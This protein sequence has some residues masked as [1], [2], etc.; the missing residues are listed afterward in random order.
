MLPPNLLY[1][2][3]DRQLL[4]ANSAPPF[5]SLLNLCHQ[6]ALAGVDFIQVREKDLTAR[7]LCYLTE[8]VLHQVRDTTTKVLINDRVDVALATGA[9]GVHLR[10][11]SLPIAAVREGIGRRLLIAASVHSLA[12]AQQVGPWADFLLAGPVFDTPS[13]RA[14]GAALGLPI[15]KDIIAAVTCPVVA[16]GGID[17]TNW[18]W[19]LNHGAAGVAA[20][21]LWAEIPDLAAF[22][23]QVKQF[24]RQNAPFPFG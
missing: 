2:I 10:E 9:H 13:K 20:I 18:Q 23:L 4:P 22:V 8:A 24:T 14:Y 7:D 5:K 6:A 11:S 12:V 15:L 16:V 21:R 1:L 3:S 17:A 19:P